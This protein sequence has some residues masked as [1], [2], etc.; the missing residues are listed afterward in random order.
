MKPDKELMKMSN[1]I[2]KI[3]ILKLVLNGWT[4]MECSNITNLIIDGHLKRVDGGVDL[5]NKGLKTL[6]E[7]L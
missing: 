5:T 3:E 4:V 7:V 6:E 2:A 1:P